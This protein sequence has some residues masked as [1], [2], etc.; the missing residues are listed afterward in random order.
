MSNDLSR[1]PG[2]LLYKVIVNPQEDGTI[3]LVMNY[4]SNWMPPR[5]TGSRYNDPV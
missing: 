3:S 1:Y 5:A 2:T 4:P